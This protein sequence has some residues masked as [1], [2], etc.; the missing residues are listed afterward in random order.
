MKKT[1]LIVDDE[2]SI[3]HTLKDILGF[4]GY[5]ILEAE[6]GPKA[7][8]IIDSRTQI[9]CILCDIKMPKMDGIEVLEYAIKQRP[10]TPVIMISGHGD[11]DTAVDAVKRGAFDYIS[12]PP[13]LN[14]L[15]QSVKSSLERSESPI[16]SPATTTKTK[17][18]STPSSKSQSILVVTRSECMKKTL[19]MIDRVAFTDARVL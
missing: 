16:T 5:D 1:I 2:R 15:L 14:K 18:S 19:D 11:I 13:D 9:D 6:D 7:V 8:E 3:R 12:K 10:Q 4:E 17:S